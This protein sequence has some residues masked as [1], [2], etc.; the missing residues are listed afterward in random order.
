M[1]DACLDDDLINV[2]VKCFGR[3]T[4]E[5][6]HTGKVIVLL[7]IQPSKGSEVVFRVLV[8]Q[9]SRSARVKP[10]AWVLFRMATD[11]T[12]SDCLGCAFV[13]RGIRSV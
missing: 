8:C 6:L 3:Q 11:H 4:C 9:D 13:V 5:F 10:I 2:P 1:L 7:F 12:R